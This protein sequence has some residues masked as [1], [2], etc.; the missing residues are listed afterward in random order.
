MSLFLY[1][2][3][4]PSVALTWANSAETNVPMPVLVLRVKGLVLSFK[5]CG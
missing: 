5:C 4:V 1:A 3:I 2:G